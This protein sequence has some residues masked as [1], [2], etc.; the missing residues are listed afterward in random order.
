MSNII[1]EVREISSQK[2][3][4]KQKASESNYPK[5]IERIKQSAGCGKTQCEFREHEIDEYSRRLLQ[6]DGFTVYTTTRPP[7][8]YDDLKYQYRDKNETVWIVSW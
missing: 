3:A 6:Q 8:K 5:L 7:N 4:E 2:I 1:Q